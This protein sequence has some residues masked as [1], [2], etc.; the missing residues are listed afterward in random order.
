MEIS[1]PKYN[2]SDGFEY[3]WEDGFEI[4]VGQSDAGI[5][6]RANRAGLKSLAIQLLTLAQEDVPINTHLHLDSY[7][8]LE[9]GSTELLIQKVGD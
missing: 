5:S 4:T 3:H 1:I 9:D 7:N 8:S 2:S 6:I